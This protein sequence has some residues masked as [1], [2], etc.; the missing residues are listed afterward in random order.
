MD[1]HLERNFDTQNRRLDDIESTLRALLDGRD[2]DP[3]PVP[4]TAGPQ[5]YEQLTRDNDR[6]RADRG[7]V[8]IDL[9]AAL[10]AE[11]RAAFE[12]WRTSTR[13]E[14]ST[15]DLAA[16]GVAGLIGMTATWFDTRVDAGV[17]G[18]LQKLSRTRLLRTWEKAGKRLPIDYMGPDFGGKAHRIRSAGHDLFRIFESTRQIMDAEF[19]GTRWA[20][21]KKSTVRV[22]GRFRGNLDNVADAL[23]V[24]LKHLAA[25]MVT[26]MGLPMPGSSLL[27]ELNDRE[28]RKLIHQAYQGTSTGNGLNLRSGIL[29]AGLP[30]IC[31]EVIIR[32]HVHAAAYEL[33]GSTALDPAQKSLRAELLLAAHSMVGAASIGKSVAR[34]L[35][36]DGDKKY[37]AVRH[38]NVPVLLRTAGLAAVVVRDARARGASG[39]ASWDELMTRTTAQASLATAVE[40]ARAMEDEEAPNSHP[41]DLKPWSARLGDVSDA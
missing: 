6:L 2:V 9:E 12:R 15:A 22:S 10:T 39:A 16:V 41:L 28:L 27:Y 19:R 20:D 31:T 37:A 24:L 4:E 25:D 1:E 3:L 32:L 11:Q 13:I 30:A 7:W 36:L 21:G 38:V 34:A 18:Q 14:W 23:I 40:L 26:P 35:S 5:S 8:E 33:T 17:L 29:S